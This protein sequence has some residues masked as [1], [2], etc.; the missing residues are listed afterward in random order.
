MVRAKPA[1]VNARGAGGTTPLME[2]A[3][4]GDVELLRTMLDAGG[5]PN[6]RNDRAASALMWAVDDIA[7]VPIAARPRRRSAMSS[8]DFSA[9]ALS[10]GAAS[11]DS[12]PLVKLLLDRGAEPTQAALNARR[13]PIPK[14]CA[15]CWRAFPTRAARRRRSRCAR[16]ATSAWR[17]CARIRKSPVPRALAVLLPPSCSRRSAAAAA[18]QCCATGHQRRPMPRTARRS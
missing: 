9:T 6:L 3:L 16:D 11:K 15:C 10:L 2:A 4:Y 8:S 17:C 18:P 13:A 12:A 7:K 5:D 1:V 14:R